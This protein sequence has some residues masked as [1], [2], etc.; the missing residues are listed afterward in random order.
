MEVKTDREQEDVSYSSLLW[1]CAISVGLGCDSTISQA[2]EVTVED[3]VDINVF[4]HQN[5]IIMNIKTNESS[6]I[7]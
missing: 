6:R 7:F 1:L 5:H 4:C 2:H 3:D